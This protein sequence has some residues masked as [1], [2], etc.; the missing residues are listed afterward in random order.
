MPKK[1]K[2][3]VEEKLESFI[4]EISKVKEEKQ[5]EIYTLHGQIRDLETRN[6]TL[7][8]D[9]GHAKD[10]AANIQSE[11]N[12]VLLEIIRWQMNHNTTRH[13]FKSVIQGGESV[14]E[15]KNF[16]GAY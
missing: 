11:H 6:Q 12:R 13:P 7:T 1:K 15:N 9:V 3:V 8:I 4:A 10:I 5:D 14:V 2:S 16:N